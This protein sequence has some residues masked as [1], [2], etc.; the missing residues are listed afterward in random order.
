MKT[1]FADTGYWI[2]LL[3]PHDTLHAKAKTVSVSLGPMRLITS[4]MVLTEYL[5]DFGRR[6]VHL[7]KTAATW[8][9]RLRMDPNTTIVPQT[10]V[11]FQDA[12]SV[13]ANRD[14]KAWSQTDC[15]SF[16][17]MQEH[18]ITEALTHDKHFQQ[19]GFKALLRE[20]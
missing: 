3:N 8:V 2:A 11:Q 4:E 15:A 12:L 9:E 10:S 5:N 1:L 20:D 16:R 19:A 13:Y 7:R 18:D 14:D 6:G 17:I